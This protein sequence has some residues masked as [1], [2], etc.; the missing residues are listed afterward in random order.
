MITPSSLP[1]LSDRGYE[2][3][4]IY[5]PGS[6]FHSKRYLLRKLFRYSFLLILLSVAACNFPSKKLSGVIEETKTAAPPVFET[7]AKPT[8]IPQ[9]PTAQQAP[10]ATTALE[11]DP[12]IYMSYG[13]QPGDTLN[14]I[15]A[16]FG[17]TPGEILSSGPL[18]T[19]GLLPNHQTL[20]IPKLAEQPPYPHFLLPDSEVVNSPCGRNFD[21]QKYVNDAAGK[22]SSYTQDVDGDILSG[23]E[24]VKL[25]AENTSTNPH[26]L[27]AFIEFR[28]QWVLGNP[29][30]TNL[31]HPLGLNIPNL[32]GL[33][34]EL[35]VYAEL[36][37]TGYYAWRQGS[38]TQLAFTDGSWVRI[39][40]ELNAGSVAVQY[41]FARMYRQDEW[42]GA[43]YG[44]NGFLS[45]YQKMF[46]DPLTCASTVEPLFPD[47][48][49]APTLE[50]PF[51]P[52]EVWALTGGLHADW[53]AG[54]PLGA[55]DFAPVTGEEP[56][57]VSRAWVLASGSGKVIRAENGV[58]QLA[59]VNQAGEETGWEL[60]YIHVAEKDRVAVGTQVNT[61]DRIGHP[62]CEGG[63]A[64][65]T[66]LHL[67]RLYRG[68]WIGAGEPFPYVLSGWIAVP[69]K[70]PYQST[71]VKGNMVVT[72]DI[73]GKTNSQI[74]R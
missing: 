69:G 21:I 30:E 35:K 55:L 39:A 28:S 27:L 48:V 73:D 36:L 42:E 2:R 16:H 31:A 68:E 15:A 11:F 54:T 12:S 58:V 50:L 71:L 19:Q 5:S 57:A 38:M 25:V 9:T 47:G 65:G 37:D 23:A 64:T 60:L 13:V 22:L 59:L 56:C 4:I 63:T 61:D 72:S 49:Q 52:G 33:F 45:A 41:L 46:G 62:S 3:I 14:S 10:T 34:N 26:F 43:L 44:M 74:V 66:N 6:H 40:P 32:E 70:A 20:A 29:P 1:I 67:A 8:L 51:T 18:P 7:Q 17:V 24:V 53:T